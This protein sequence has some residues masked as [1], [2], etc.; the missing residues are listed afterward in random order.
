M[1][2]AFAG[3]DPWFA[4]S[5]QER[6]ARGEITSDQCLFDDQYFIRG[7][8]DIPIIGQRDRFVWS[9][10]VSVSRQSFILIQDLWDADIRSDQPPLFGWLC[11]EI[12]GYPSTYAL[13]THVH[14]RDHGTR[15]FIEL[16]PTD[17][18]LATEQREGITLRGVEKIISGTHSH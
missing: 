10:W 13:K 18:P 14:L 6:E 1:S 9:V 17:H 5:E 7:C 2:L 11:N 16:E 15:P 4:L 8:L 12:P 3:P